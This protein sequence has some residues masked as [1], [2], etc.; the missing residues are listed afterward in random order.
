MVVS[1]I[2][3]TAMMVPAMAPLSTSWRIW[4]STRVTHLLR[5]CRSMILELVSDLISN[6][7][8]RRPRSGR[9]E[10]WMH[11]TDSLPSFETRPSGAPQDDVR[12]VYG[13]PSP[14]QE[15]PPDVRVRRQLARR[16]G[17][18]G[19]PVDQNVGAVRHRQRFARVLLD[20]HDRYFVAVDR[21]DV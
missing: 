9:L 8:L 19:A 4:V 3:G 11:G 17:A 2:A 13:P 18:A 1:P 12:N 5:V 15:Y 16:A 20:Q 7:I 10:G 14:A 6:V 21:A